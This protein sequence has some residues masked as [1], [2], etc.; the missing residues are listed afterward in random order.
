M[1]LS[2][3]IQEKLKAISELE[4]LLYPLL[5]ER[6]KEG[7]LSIL[8]EVQERLK[9]LIGKIEKLLQAK[10]NDHDI[11]QKALRFRE[12]DPSPRGDKLDDD[13]HKVES[14]S[15]PH[16]E[17][18]GDTP[19]MGMSL[20]PE[21]VYIQY[22]DIKSKAGHYMSK[23]DSETK[24]QITVSQSDP[25]LGILQFRDGLDEFSKREIQGDMGHPLIRRES[26]WGGE[27]RSQGT[28]EDGEVRLDPER[29]HWE[30]KTPITIKS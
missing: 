27:G 15:I 16:D 4:V 6:D 5:L 23:P 30:L 8:S 11:I 18:P 24:F 28:Y 3:Q 2:E 20:P 1:N 17:P 19:A 29:K 10:E 26:S 12:C 7:T 9:E 25:S 21:V 14:S 13:D 22:K